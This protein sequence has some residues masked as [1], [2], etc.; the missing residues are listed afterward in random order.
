MGIS[1][2]ATRRLSLGSPDDVWALLH[3]G[4]GVCALPALWHRPHPAPA[5]PAQLPAAPAHRPAQHAAP[6]HSTAA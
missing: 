4:T 6:I 3:T 2:P 5:L 1:G